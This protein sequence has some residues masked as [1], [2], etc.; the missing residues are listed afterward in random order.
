MT[1]ARRVLTKQA[2]TDVGRTIL[3]PILAIVVLLAVGRFAGMVT[4]PLF[5]STEGRYASTARDLVENDHWIVPRICLHGEW[6]P[7][8]GKPPLAFWA[9]GVSARVFG[10]NEAAVRL[11]SFLAGLAMLGL[12]WLAARRLYG[13]VV[14]WTTV[15]VASSSMFFFI[16]WGLVTTDVIASLCVA[17]AIVSYVMG[18]TEEP[19][20]LR[21][22]WRAALF[23]FLSAGFI[24]KGP[25]V[26]ILA[27]VP[28]L[29]HAWR[30]KSIGELRRFP[31]VKGTVAALVIAAVWLFVA[32]QHSPGFT[33][34]FVV[35]EHLSRYLDSNFADPYG[36]PHPHPFGMVWVWA[37]AA[38]L[39]WGLALV[40]F[41]RATW[42][43]ITTLLRNDSWTVLLFAW[44]LW[45][46]VFFTPSRAAL[47]TYVLPGVVAGSI[48]LARILVHVASIGMVQRRALT[49]FW[50]FFSVTC[51]IGT[52]ASV[53]QS[54]LIVAQV[55]GTCAVACM[56]SGRYLKRRELSW[57]VVPVWL[58]LTSVSCGIGFS[59]RIEEK[60]ASPRR[61]IAA[62]QSCRQPH[63]PIIALRRWE[64][65]MGFYAPQDLRY[66]N[67][68]DGPEMS[69]LVHDD[70]RDVFIIRTKYLDSIP[71]EHASL[72]EE[73]GRYGVFSVLL[74][75]RYPVSALPQ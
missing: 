25:V 22:A 12:A 63:G 54:N 30:T 50:A 15:L 43:Q 9:A 32:E 58:T 47:P 35:H 68:P 73:C 24:V 48:V 74:D 6:V 40:V 64:H 33:R 49:F 28:I 26:V 7:Y 67:R 53:I 11:P 41:G 37:I 16:L 62:A 39:P 36:E 3:V 51:W 27:V 61:A 19:R 18:S 31:L 10:M 59:S 13:T 17:G 8:W 72:L 65:A 57:A 46:A 60:I 29:L 71:P 5:G 34:H 42:R 23:A 56:A 55:A 1:V 4:T 14:A 2:K 70:Q 66:V 69:R 38:Q 21:V 75:R 20:R 52:I 45:P 44:M